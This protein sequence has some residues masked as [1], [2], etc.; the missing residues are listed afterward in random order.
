[1][2]GISLLRPRVINVL[3]NNNGIVCYLWKFRNNNT[4]ETI[5]YRIRQSKTN[6]NILFKTIIRGR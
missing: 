2:G 5:F 1:M 4:F 6:E 3:F